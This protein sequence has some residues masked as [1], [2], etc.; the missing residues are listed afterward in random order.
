MITLWKANKKNNYEA[1][2]STNT[3]LRDEIKKKIILKKDIKK[4]ESTCVRFSNSWPGLA[5]PGL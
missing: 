1:K 4:F 3:M 5:C 2:F